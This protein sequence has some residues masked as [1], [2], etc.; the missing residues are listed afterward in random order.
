MEHR[1][2]LFACRRFAGLLAFVIATA[3]GAAT[4]W[5]P[6]STVAGP[7]P[8]GTRVC[9]GTYGRSCYS[10]AGNQVCRSGVVCAAGQ[11]VCAGPAGASCYSAAAGQRCLS[12]VV[13]GPGQLACT[14]GG[15]TQ[16]YDP[17]RGQ[18]CE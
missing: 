4:P 14:I 10:P 9:S 7:C 11:Q 6:P 17:A 15:V 13:C 2:C 3:A 18:Q 12:G 16:C 1:P 5:Q 8:A